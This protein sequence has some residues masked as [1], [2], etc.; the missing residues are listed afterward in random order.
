MPTLT[1]HR[2]KGETE[3]VP[4]TLRIDMPREVDYYMR[5]GILPCAET[6]DFAELKASDDCPIAL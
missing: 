4:V 5:G 2:A 6:V 3:Q 1:I